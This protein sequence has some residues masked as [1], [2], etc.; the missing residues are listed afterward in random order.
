MIRRVFLGL[1]VAPRIVWAQAATGWRVVWADEFDGAA[2]SPPDPAK[3]GYDIGD[4]SPGNPGWGN[5]EKEVYTTSTS[6]AFQDG[7]GHLV[8]Q[9]LN[10]NGAYTSGRIK[11]QNTFTFTYGKVEARIKLPYAQGIWPA[12]WLLGADISR[13]VQWPACGEVDVVENFGVQ[14][15][16]ASVNHG[17]IHGPNYAGTGVTATYTLPGNQAISADFHSFSIEWEPGRIEFFVEGVSYLKTT[18]AS[19]PRGGQWVFDNNPMFLLLNLAVGGS[20]APVGYPDAS[21]PFPQQMIVDYVRVYQRTQPLRH[22]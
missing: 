21:T 11:T 1:L 15:N 9:A 17:T 3:W 14:D 5:N 4:G 22:R 2:N 7:N 12:F 6:N 20:P 16:D 19:L 8:I 18:P 13:G 10:N